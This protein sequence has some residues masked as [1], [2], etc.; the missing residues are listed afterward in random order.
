M[1]WPLCKMATILYWPRCVK[2]TFHTRTSKIKQDQI[3][4]SQYFYHLNNEKAYF[5]VQ[6][7]PNFEE[8]LN[9][10]L[11]WQYKNSQLENDIILYRFY[12]Y[13]GNPYIIQDRMVFIFKELPIITIVPWSRSKWAPSTATY[14]VNWG[15]QL[16]G[17]LSK[18]DQ[19]N[20]RMSQLINLEARP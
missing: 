10:Q 19:G 8:K 16:E 13:D 9:L 20:R 14:Y 17:C 5:T 3:L 15:P 11:D 2:R 4:I 7:K 12:L 6:N 1:A 18:I